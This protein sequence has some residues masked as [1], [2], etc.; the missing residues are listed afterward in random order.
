MV[1]LI[2]VIVAIISTIF[3][4]HA[5]GIHQNRKKHSKHK[6]EDSLNW[7]ITE[8]DKEQILQNMKAI[9]E[10]NLP[11]N[12]SDFNLAINGTKY[13]SVLWEIDQH[14][15]AK[16]KYDED[17]TNEQHDVYQAVRDQLREYMSESGVT[18]DI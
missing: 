4:A 8:E 14:L 12:Q 3:V 15:R 9:L 17:L 16:I 18:F 13:Y 10:F 2:I 5:S 1:G 11:D 6:K 7:D